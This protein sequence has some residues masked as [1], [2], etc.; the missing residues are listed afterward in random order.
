[1]SRG[2]AIPLEQEMVRSG[3]IVM[4]N[5]ILRPGMGFK[6][7]K[8]ECEGMWDKQKSC[9]TDPGFIYRV[10]TDTYWQEALKKKTVLPYMGLRLINAPVY[11]DLSYENGY[12]LQFREPSQ[13][14]RKIWEEMNVH[15]WYMPLDYIERVFKWD[16]QK[17]DWI[18]QEEL[19][20]AVL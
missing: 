10:I 9:R 3:L 16:D 19:K 7:W 13:I 17:K 2:A 5:S 1:M 4:A 8:R 6:E 20:P 18:W 11:L 12:I 15:L 14:Q